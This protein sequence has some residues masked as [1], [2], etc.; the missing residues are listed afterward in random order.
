[1]RLDT[2]KASIDGMELG[3]II[4]GNSRGLYHVTPR[5]EYQNV[6][7]EFLHANG[8]DMYGYKAGHKSREYD[9]GTF[10]IRPYY[11][12]EDEEIA[13]LP[14]FEF[15]PTGLQIK[16]YKYP[17]RD[18][19]SNMDISVEEMKYILAGCA[20]SLRKPVRGERANF[21]GEPCDDGIVWVDIR[22][23]EQTLERYE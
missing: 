20:A 12:G 17:M 2:E 11:W 10:V 16:W 23:G 22:S 4:F 7:C 1:M 9:N 5:E 19:Y 14:N 18:A 21:I 3:N 13:A 15:K 6:F 8:F